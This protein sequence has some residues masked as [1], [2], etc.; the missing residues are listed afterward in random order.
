MALSSRKLK[1]KYYHQHEVIFWVT[2]HWENKHEIPEIIVLELKN[3]NKDNVY[4]AKLKR[5][6]GLSFV[7]ICFF[8]FLPFI[9]QFCSKNVFF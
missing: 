1:R 3:P 4:T 2:N 8:V 6:S 9:I 5:Y 7:I